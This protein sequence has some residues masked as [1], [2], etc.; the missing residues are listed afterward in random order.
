MG[1]KFFGLTA[2][3]TLLG[4]V[5]LAHSTGID[6]TTL[7]LNGNATAPT[8]NDLNLVDG[9]GGEASSG[10]LKSAISTGDSFTSTFSFTLVANPNNPDNVSPQAD[11]LAFVIQSQGPTAL[12][13]GGSGIGAAGIL[14]SVGIGFQSWVNDHATIFV[15]PD[16]PDGGDKPKN[17]FSLGAQDDTV[18]VSVQYSS[19]LLSYIATNLSTSQ[20]ISDSLAV[21]LSTLGPGVFLGFT[22]GSGL[23]YSFEDVTNW[24]VTVTPLPATWTMMLI[25]LALFG[26]GAYRGTRRVEG[27]FVAA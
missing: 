25:G 19:G 27:G 24:D 4:P 1:V 14:S 3:L 23:G 7:Q 11:G 20:T 22:G 5:S 9:K 6:L 21:D 16:S 17:N 2:A 8:A 12:G 26:F 10:F 13:T 15:S 18:S